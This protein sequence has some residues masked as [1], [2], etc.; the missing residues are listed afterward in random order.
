MK[1]ERRNNGFTLV[2]VLVALAVAAIALTALTQAGGRYLETQAG[3]EQR[4]AATW[5]AQN[6]IVRLQSGLQQTL[7]ENIE[8]DYAQRR[9]IIRTAQQQTPVPGMVQ[10]RVAVYMQGA[11]T[12]S[13]TLV[14]VLAP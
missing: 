4:M 3:L 10:L 14:T 1:S 12:P 5:L 11:K 6:E 9:W 2:E 8:V 13:A 7:K